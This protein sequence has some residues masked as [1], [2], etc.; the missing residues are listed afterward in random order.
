MYSE[1]QCNLWPLPS[2]SSPRKILWV[3]GVG[4]A[5]KHL[6]RD[7]LFGEQPHGRDDLGLAIT[8]QPD[9]HAFK[10]FRRWQTISRHRIAVH[11]AQCKCMKKMKS[12][13]G[14]N[15]VLPQA[16]VYHRTQSVRVLHAENFPNTRRENAINFR[17]LD[18]IHAALLTSTYLTRPGA[19]VTHAT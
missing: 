16:C 1:F 6:R 13:L 9:L 12:N 11:F 10:T 3:A 18:N 15:S 7:P 17:K 14:I 2:L 5:A 19:Q 8:K 4:A